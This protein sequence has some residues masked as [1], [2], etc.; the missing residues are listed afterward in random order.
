MLT[1]RC[2]I[3]VGSLKKTGKLIYSDTTMSVQTHC[4]SDNKAYPSQI[5]A[6]RMLHI[7]DHFNQHSHSLAET[8]KTDLQHR[9]QTRRG[10]IIAIHSQPL[11]QILIPNILLLVDILRNLMITSM[12]G[13]QALIDHQIRQR[14]ALDRIE[15]L[16]LFISVDVAFS[17][18]YSGDR[19]AW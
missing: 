3:D 14:S 1:I 6:N 19:L 18:G 15:E 11:P 8:T 12:T 7:K 5:L 10:P 17:G 9:P 2:N 13:H 4:P 16:V